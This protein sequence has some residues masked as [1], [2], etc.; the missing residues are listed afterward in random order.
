[1]HTD[2]AYPFKAEFH[3]GSTAGKVEGTI[4][5]LTEI[6]A[7]DLQLDVHGNTM[8]ELYPLIACRCRQR[9]PIT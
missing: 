8:E 3:A 5:G 4:T 6:K 2:E 9:R 1:M 7:A